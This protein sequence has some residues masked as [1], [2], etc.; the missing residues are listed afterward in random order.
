MLTQGGLTLDPGAGRAPV[1]EV[2][3]LTEAMD[4]KEVGV[5]LR[6]LPYE[7]PMHIDGIPIGYTGMWA[8]VDCD[9]DVRWGDTYPVLV[10]DGSGGLG[11]HFKWIP[12]EPGLHCL[13]VRV[14]QDP[15]Q[16]S[17]GGMDSQ[18]TPVMTVRVQVLPAQISDLD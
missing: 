8:A 16:G 18:G 14:C 4:R 3:T 13:T 5:L 9:R 17:L 1:A 15:T 6:E 2:E 11:F 7:Y 10:P 12:L